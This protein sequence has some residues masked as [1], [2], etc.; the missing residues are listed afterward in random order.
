MVAVAGLPFIKLGSLLLKQ[1]AKPL[2]ARLKIEAARSPRL[3]S[4]LQKTGQLMHSIS[5]R[6]TVFAS[7]FKFLGVKPLPEDEA[8][9]AGIEFCSES[10]LVI[11]GASIIIYEYDKAE[12]KNQ[13]KT[14]K[15][16]EKE[17]EDRKLLD[18][19]FQNIE[20]ELSQ[21]RDSV[22][23]LEENVINEMKSPRQK[24]FPKLP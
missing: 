4:F 5:S 10:F 11:T 16:L 22:R 23:Q 13:I 8:L 6:I 18:Q 20:L 2:S 24:W 19:R 14:Q 21:L 1:L 7:G 17:A 15:L 9:K 3:S 12:R